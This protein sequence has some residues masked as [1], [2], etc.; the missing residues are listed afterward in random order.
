MGIFGLS[1]QEKNMIAMSPEAFITY[2]NTYRCKH[3]GK[4]WQKISH[5]E[6]LIPRQSLV[7]DQEKT[8]Y[9]VHIEEEEARE[10]QYLRE[11]Q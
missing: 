11:E 5:E 7:D 10:E 1:E 9:D 8:D 3:C 4:E 6:K 2:K